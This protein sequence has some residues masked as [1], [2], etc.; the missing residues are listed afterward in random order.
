VREHADAKS[1]LMHPSSHTQRENATPRHTTPRHCQNQHTS[2]KPTLCAV[3]S[4]VSKSMMRSRSSS[5]RTTLS[6]MRWYSGP[7]R[8]TPMSG[9]NSRRK[10]VIT[11]R[12]SNNSSEH[13]AVMA[14]SENAGVCFRASTMTRDFDQ[15]VRPISWNCAGIPST[16]HMNGTYSASNK[17]N[18]GQFL[19]YLRGKIDARDGNELRCPAAANEQAYH[20]KPPQKH[21]PNTQSP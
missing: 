20:E 18:P 11:S 2:P 19:T 15:R 14:V 17:H 10:H 5:H 7:T 1:L 21:H 16:T 13:C 6:R 3:V 4:V 12:S 8:S 9:F